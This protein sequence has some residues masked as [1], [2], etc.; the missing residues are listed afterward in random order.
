MKSDGRKIV[1]FD[2]DED[3]VSICKF[4][5]EEIGW[6]VFTFPDCINPLEKVGQI[7]PDIIL[8]DNWLPDLGGVVTTQILKNV[9]EFKN[10]PII[11]FSA[12]N[13]IQTIAETAGADAFLPKPFDVSDLEKIINAHLK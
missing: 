8:M 6:E 3:I 10:I 9:E 5:L 13:D 11:F 2:D 1:I 12:N 7:M 4:I